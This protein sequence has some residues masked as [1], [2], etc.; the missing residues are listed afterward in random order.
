MKLSA[1]ANEAVA[2]A[3]V[4]IWQQEVAKESCRSR[5]WNTPRRLVLNTSAPDVRESHAKTD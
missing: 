5:T 2:N 3:Q 1:T 4:D